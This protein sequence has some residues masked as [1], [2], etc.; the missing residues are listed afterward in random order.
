MDIHESSHVPIAFGRP[1]PATVGDVI[2]V[3]MGKILF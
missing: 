2:D 1:F 3:P